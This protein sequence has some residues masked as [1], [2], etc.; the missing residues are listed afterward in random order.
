M[1]A[2]AGLSSDC[3][4]STSI[5]RDV[6]PGFAQVLERGLQHHVDDAALG[7]REVAAFDLGVPAVAAEEVVDDGEHELRLEQDQRRAAQR[8]DAH[9]VQAR[10]HVQRVH[11]LAE[12]LH[13]DRVH[14]HFGRAAQQVVEVEA[15]QARE[16]LVDHLER[17]HAPAHDAHLV[18]E[19]EARAPRPAAAAPARCS[20]RPGPCRGSGR[21][22]RPGSGFSV[23]RSLRLGAVT[24]S[25]SW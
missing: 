21:R 20:P 25:R 4:Y 7:G 15:E 14:R 16:A 17:G 24:A 2:N 13:L 22:S 6:R 23:R 10:G 3:R 9:Q 5:V 8:V 1:F 18:L 12:L 19:V 11:V